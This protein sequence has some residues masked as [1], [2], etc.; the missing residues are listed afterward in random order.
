MVDSRKEV[1]VANEH[2]K[3]YGY[4]VPE[5]IQ[6]LVD[7]GELKDLSW[8]NDAA[9]SYGVVLLDDVNVSIWVDHVDEEKRGNEGERFFVSVYNHEYVNLH[10]HNDGQIIGTDNVDEAIAKWRDTVIDL[11][12]QISDPRPKVCEACGVGLLADRTCPACGV[13]HTAAPCATCGRVGL[14]KD[15]CTE[16]PGHDTEGGPA[17]VAPVTKEVKIANLE[18]AESDWVEVYYA[19]DDKITLIEAGNYGKTDRKVNVKE[20]LTQLKSIR[21]RIA[22]N[23]TV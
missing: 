18:L 16:P 23:V 19:L 5:E 1:P 8:H 13:S 7:S 12:A 20:W 15:D 14:H 6:A 17:Y 11:K 10:P 2:F 9:P 21:D 22:D 4:T 3:S